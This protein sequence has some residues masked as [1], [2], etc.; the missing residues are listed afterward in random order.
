VMLPG[1]PAGTKAAAKE[2][3]SRIQRPTELRGDDVACAMF[4]QLLWWKELIHSIAAL[5]NKL[6]HCPCDN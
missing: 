2:I 3:T 5:G 4:I 1:V 6:E